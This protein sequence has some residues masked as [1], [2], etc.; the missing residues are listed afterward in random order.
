MYVQL[1]ILLFVT[2]FVK[3]HVHEVVKLIYHFVWEDQ[4]EL[5]GSI[6]YIVLC[7]VQYLDIAQGS[8]F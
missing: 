1:L 4:R 2:A 6:S 5:Q 3:H 7:T 8:G